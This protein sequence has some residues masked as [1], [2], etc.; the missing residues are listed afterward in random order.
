[1][2]LV[3]AWIVTVL[4]CVVAYKYATNEYMTERPFNITVYDK[5]KVDSSKG[6]VNLAVVYETDNGVFFDRYVSPSTYATSHVGESYALMLRPFD[7]KQ[8]RWQNALYFVGPVV[9]G[10]I[11][12]TLF[13]FL[14]VHSLGVGMAAMHHD[15]KPRW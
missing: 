15:L 13:C 9:F 12:I 4:M 11:S 10:A 8:T 6:R 5:M 2:K 1:M 7:V 3:W 14:L